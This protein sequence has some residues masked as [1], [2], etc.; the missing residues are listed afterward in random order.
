MNIYNIKIEI[1]IEIEAFNEIDAREY[2]SEIFGTDEEV[3]RVKVLT[4]NE[5]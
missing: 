2:V 1:D 5:K 4:V 3:K